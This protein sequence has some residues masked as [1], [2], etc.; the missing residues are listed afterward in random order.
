[1]GS[2]FTPIFLLAI[3]SFSFTT[4]LHF[5]TGAINRGGITYLEL[6]CPQDVFNQ[7]VENSEDCTQYYSCVSPDYAAKMECSECTSEG[8]PEGACCK[9]RTCYNP[10]TGNCDWCYN[11][12]CGS[13]ICD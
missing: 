13:T 1:M 4:L 5:S 8:N 12:N 2:S 7:T 9:G 3:F 11:V 6:A 10:E